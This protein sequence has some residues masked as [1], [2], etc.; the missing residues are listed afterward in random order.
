MASVQ[1]LQPC[2]AVS[3]SPSTRQCLHSLPVSLSVLFGPPAS[4]SFSSQN[5]WRTAWR[6]SDIP[7]VKMAEL[8]SSVS[9][10]HSTPRTTSVSSKSPITSLPST[11]ALIDAYLQYR[12]TNVLGP[13]LAACDAVID[14]STGDMSSSS[15]SSSGT[16]KHF[17][18]IS[19]MWKCA[20]ASVYPSAS[21][22]SA[23]LYKSAATFLLATNALSPSS[24][25]PSTH[26]ALTKKKVA[27]TVVSGPL[28]APVG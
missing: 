26:D 28:G 9:T 11:S 5:R 21:D 4:I 24:A 2:L 7:E 18:S 14:P 17:S 16:M 1:F 20:N 6:L 8:V 25:S 10:Q 13:S 27:V 22:S 23:V 3:C 12:L 19:R 15:T